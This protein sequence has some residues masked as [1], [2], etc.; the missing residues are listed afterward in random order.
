MASKLQGQDGDLIPDSD[1][2]AQ[3]KTFLRIEDY[4]TIREAVIDTVSAQRC[5]FCGTSFAILEHFKQHVTGQEHE[6]CQLHQEYITLPELKEMR[7]RQKDAQN[8]RLRT[9]SF[10][11][12]R[13]SGTDTSATHI[14]STP[15]PSLLAL[16][17]AVTTSPIENTQASHGQAINCPLVQRQSLL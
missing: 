4:R 2:T 5:P 7:V 8:L 11:P 13:L 15:S 14:Q 12:T 16:P 10:D 9:C 17:G 6:N 1:N 3:D